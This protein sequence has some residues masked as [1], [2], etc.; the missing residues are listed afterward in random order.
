MTEITVVELAI[1]HSDTSSRSNKMAIEGLI[2][3]KVGCDKC[4][5]E[6]SACL[7]HSAEYYAELRKL[8]AK[9]GTTY[10]I[11]SN[12]LMKGRKN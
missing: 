10:E 4:E 9:K 12:Q 6:K 1:R 2:P 5:A 11:L 8:V 7:I 3:K